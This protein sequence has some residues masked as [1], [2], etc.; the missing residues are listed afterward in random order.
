MFFALSGIA[1][2][3][4]LVCL[5]IVIIKLFQDDK[6]LLGV[7]SIPCGLVAFVYGWMNVDRYRIR[8]VMIVWSIALVISLG[9]GVLIP[10]TTITTVNGQTTG[11][12]V[13]P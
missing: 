4:N 7:L 5:I 10:H 1:G 6:I 9:S 3:V 12:T 8:N 2:L 13:T 11:T